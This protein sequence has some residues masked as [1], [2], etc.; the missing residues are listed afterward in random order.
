MAPV[1]ESGSWPTW[2]ALVAKPMC[3]PLGAKIEN[4]QALIASRTGGD[5]RDAWAT[6]INLIVQNYRSYNCESIEA[7][8][9]FV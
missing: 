1:V 8:R 5:H 4:L 3:P 6:K 9:G 7:C 2:M